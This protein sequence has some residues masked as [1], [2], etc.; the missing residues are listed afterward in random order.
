MHLSAQRVCLQVLVPVR[1]V[2]HVKPH[3]A[4]M[5]W[6]QVM[7]MP[8]MSA[9]CWPHGCTWTAAHRAV[10]G[11]HQS[12]TP[13]R[14]RSRSSRCCGWQGWVPW[15]SNWPKR[16]RTCL[17]CS[18]FDK[19]Q[20]SWDKCTSCAPTTEYEWQT[21]NHM[22]NRLCLSQ[23]LHLDRLSNCAICRT[24]SPAG[25]SRPLRPHRP[26][27]RAPRGRVP[28]R[29]R[30]LGVHLPR[31]GP[32]R[33]QGRAAAAPARHAGVGRI[34]LWHSHMHTL[35]LAAY[36]WAASSKRTAGANTCVQALTRRSVAAPPAAG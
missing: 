16:T 33:G 6:L 27:L 3:V 12:L 36:T 10:Q 25:R 22:R 14:R 35:M 19:P 13:G 20:V 1:R 18:C 21:V 32:A 30:V 9:T 23:I 7:Q 17:P 26:H 11:R 24:T 5:C 2:D 28:A 4:A 8:S 31:G 29:P 15:S 34:H